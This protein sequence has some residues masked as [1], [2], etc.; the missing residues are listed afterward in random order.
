[1]GKKDE[2]Y[3]T[4]IEECVKI[5]EIIKQKK[6][7]VDRMMKNLIGTNTFFEHKD[8]RKYTREV[9][10]KSIINCIFDKEE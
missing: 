5:Q 7:W 2:L 3:D 1:M 6:M 9:I 4:V 10:R 8:I